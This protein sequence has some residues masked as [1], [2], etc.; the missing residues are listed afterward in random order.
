MHPTIDLMFFDLPIY[1]GLA[2][3]GSATGLVVAYLF[4]RARSR[5]LATLSTFLNG[6]V[7]VFVAGWVGARLYHV[8]VNWDYYAARPSEIAEVGLGGMAMRGALIAGFIG[9]ALYSRVSRIQFNKL[10]DAAA[11]GLPI[12]QAIGWIGAL[13]WGANYGVVSDN[14][15]AMD[16][17]DLYGL[18]A[19]RFPLQLAEIILYAGLFLILC[20]LALRK[21][22]AGTLFSV[23]LLVASA[24]NF[25]LGFQRGDSTRYLGTLSIDQWVDAA[26]A[27]IATAHMFY[28]AVWQT[29]KLETR[30]E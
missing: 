4:L 24:A 20:V 25:A 14:Q 28:T 22:R 19:P 5:R 1:T 21:L 3:L 7:T 27:I 18:V 30:G 8:A 9:L 23:Y 6:A 29:R 17:P 10:G 13:L 11:M 2:M 26:L 12:G 16:L 15:V